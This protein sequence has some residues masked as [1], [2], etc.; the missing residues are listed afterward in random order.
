MKYIL[1]ILSLF[2]LNL[3]ESALRGRYLWEKKRIKQLINHVKFAYI[4]IF[5]SLCLNIAI[6]SILVDDREIS[7]KTT[8]G[9][10]I[11]TGLFFLIIFS[12]PMIRLIFNPEEKQLK[13]KFRQE[14]NEWFR[15]EILQNL[16]D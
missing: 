16:K 5:V 9:L 1:G 14:M 8:T 15:A 13:I 7:L 11:V 6:L 12:I 2:S 10:I 3:F 4:M